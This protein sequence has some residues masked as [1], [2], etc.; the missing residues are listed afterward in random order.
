MPRNAFASVLAWLVVASVSA[1]L[2]AG[3]I[4][5]DRFDS[6]YTSLALQPQ[7]N[8]VGRVDFFEPC[9][10]TLVGPNWVLTAGHLSGVTLVK[11]GTGG[12]GDKV[13]NVLQDI[14][15]PGWNGDVLHGNDMRLLK[16]SGNP[17]DD[18]KATVIFPLYRG[19]VLDQVVTNVGYG[20]TGDGVTGFSQNT[21]GTRRAGNMMIRSY[22]TPDPPAFNSTTLTRTTPTNMMLTDFISPISGQNVSTILSI[23]NNSTTFAT[24]QDLEYMLAPLDSGSPALI[25]DNGVW[26]VAGV[27]SFI[28]TQNPDGQPQGIYGD[29]SGFSILDDANYTW[30]YNIAVPEPGSI[31]LLSLI[32]CGGAGYGWHRYRRQ[33]RD[34]NALVPE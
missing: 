11:F 3:D 2:W 24:P 4:R 25:N 30:A 9:A 34:Q 33:R 32:V 14:P 17:I 8:G 21:F 7:F 19:P 18:G 29:V 28:L 6:S 16:I 26:K 22:L 13:Y 23:I 10:C 15:A 12:A 5:H 20:N 27:G 31:A 1:P